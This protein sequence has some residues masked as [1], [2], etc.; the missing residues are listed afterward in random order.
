MLHIENRVGERILKLLLI[1]WMNQYDLDKKMQEDFLE[2]FQ[3]TVNSR[4]LGTEQRKSNWLI[5]LTQNKVIADRPM[6]NNHTQRI[7]N[8]LKS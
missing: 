1:E 6:T 5:N 2:R 8:F 3:D 7:I 4:I